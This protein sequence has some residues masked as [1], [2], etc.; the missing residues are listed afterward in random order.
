MRLRTLLLIALILLMAA[1][2]ALNIESIL[3]PTTLYLAVAEVQAPLGLVMV[4]ML[5]AVLVIF[6]LAL[7][8]FQATHVMEVRQITREANEQRALADKA[9]SSR[10][11]ALQEFLRSELQAMAGRDTQL[12]N[13][14]QQK[15]DLVQ[16]ALATTIEQ[17][18]NGISASLGELE[19]RLDHQSP[20]GGAER[21]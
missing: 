14:L 10:F 21:T 3:Q 5:A 20:P 13:Q 15:M 19:D 18:G 1:F 9:E 16:T 17:T 11:T 2:V 4:G 8:Y 12:S 7:V 6:L